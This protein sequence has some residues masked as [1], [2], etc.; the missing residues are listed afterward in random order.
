MCARTGPLCSSP[1]I[2]TRS[3][4]EQGQ[5]GCVCA[6]QSTG[7]STQAHA[8]PSVSAPS[9]ASPP[10]STHTTRVYLEAD[11]REELPPPPSACLQESFSLEGPAV[12]PSIRAEFMGMPPVAHLLSLADRLLLPPPTPWLVLVKFAV[13]MP[14]G[15]ALPRPPP[16]PPPSCCCTCSDKDALRFKHTQAGEAGC[17]QAAWV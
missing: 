6:G 8:P 14:G 2:L 11:E 12:P 15:G 1:G 10:C 13:A 3:C 9:L 4:R 16:P 17:V 5:H 7:A